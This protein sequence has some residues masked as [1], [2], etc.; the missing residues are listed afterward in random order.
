[1]ELEISLYGGINLNSRLFFFS[2][3]GI[4]LEDVGR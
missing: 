1:M 2:S 3:L 4:G